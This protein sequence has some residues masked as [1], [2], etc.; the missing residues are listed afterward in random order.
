MN[1]RRF[2]YRNIYLKS[3]GWARTRGEILKR[4]RR[5][6]KR[7]SEKRRLHVHHVN[8]RGTPKMRWWHFIPFIGHLLIWHKDTRSTMQTLCHKHHR[9]AHGAKS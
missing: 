9:M 4:D 6:C 3:P 8:Y 5:K 7:C 1:I 2:W